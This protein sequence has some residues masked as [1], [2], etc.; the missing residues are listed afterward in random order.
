MC[1]TPSVLEI[2][3]HCSQVTCFVSFLQP[4]KPCS[5]R[6]PNVSLTVSTA[7]TGS[8]SWY[9]LAVSLEVLQQIWHGRRAHIPQSPVV[10]LTN[11]WAM[12]PVQWA[13][14]L[15]FPGGQ[16]LGATWTSS[17][18]FYFV[19]K[20]GVLGFLWA[21][22]IT[23]CMGVGAQHH[24]GTTLLGPSPLETAQCI[25]TPWAHTST[26]SNLLQLSPENSGL[27]PIT[28]QFLFSQRFC[29]TQFCLCF[30]ALWQPLVPLTHLKVN[31]AQVTWHSA[32]NP[33]L[34]C[35]WLK[36]TF[37]NAPGE[38]FGA[39]IQQSV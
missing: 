1:T 8:P 19:K 28:C 15:S 6:N 31:S 30:P 36:V 7:R 37:K 2:A 4:K 29:N 20:I 9:L 10:G 17:H 22:H 3:A 35:V 23:W 26:A 16:W 21:A 18:A 38:T 5:I 33:H 25:L 39:L 32:G 12:S 11:G 27:A 14:L 13:R 34:C 24:F